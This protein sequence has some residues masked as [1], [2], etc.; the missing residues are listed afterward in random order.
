MLKKIKDMFYPQTK[1]EQL[2][3]PGTRVAK[4]TD[5]GTEFGEVV[6]S[7]MHGPLMMKVF[8]KM[9]GLV[10]HRMVVVPVGFSATADGSYL[11]GDDEIT[12]RLDSRER[13]SKTHLDELTG[14]MS[15]LRDVK[16][17]IA[18]GNVAAMVEFLVKDK[19]FKLE[20]DLDK[21]IF[22]AE[23]NLGYIMDV[24]DEWEAFKSKG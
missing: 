11:F 19:V 13:E 8:I 16:D 24:K 3:K 20:H 9:K 12:S 17:A 18:M 10:N 22:K 23:K 5:V 7:T 4:I 15:Q 6:Y 1:D 14:H 2:I 21:E